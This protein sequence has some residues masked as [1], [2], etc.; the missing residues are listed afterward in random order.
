[1]SLKLIRQALNRHRPPPRMWRAQPLKKRYDVIIIGGGGSDILEG[2][3]GDDIIDRAIQFGA[4]QLL[5]QH[6]G[7]WDLLAARANLRGRAGR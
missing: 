4:R 1:M 6:R 7:L 2:R 3:G 5:T